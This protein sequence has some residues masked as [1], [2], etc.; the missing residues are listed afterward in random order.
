MTKRLNVWMNGELVGAW[1][2]SSSGRAS[3][4]Y[5]SGWIHSG[6]GRPLSLSIPF[7]AGNAVQ[8]GPVVEDYFENLLPDSKAIRDRMR[9]RFHIRSSSTIDLLAAIG[10]DCVGAAQLLP[11][12]VTPENWRTV[13]AVRLNEA[14][15]AN[16]LRAVPSISGLQ[17]ED[18]FR[19]SIAGAQEKTA[20]LRYAG[21]WHSPH[22]ATPT[23]HILKLP[24]GLVGGMRFNLSESVE[25]EW[26]CAKFLS[27]LGLRVAATEMATFEDQKVLVVERFDRRWIGVDTADVNKARFKPGSGTWIARLPQEDFCQI[28]GVPPTQKYPADGGPDM[29]KCLSYLKNS[30]QAE[31]DQRHFCLSQLAFWL[32]AATDGHAKN[33]SISLLAGGRYRLTPLYDVLSAWPVI[34]HGANR[35]PIQKAKLAMGVP[36]KTTHYR[37]QDI[38]ARHWYS[39]AVTCLGHTVW[40]SMQ[41]LVERV[42]AALDEVEKSLPADFP[43]HVWTTIQKGV[44]DQVRIFRKE[45]P[46]VEDPRK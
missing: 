16:L 19:I 3:F 6:Y 5:D 33:F 41:D 1:W 34:G 37:L 25:N 43:E 2:Y 15:I 22:G 44:R 11:E 24:L 46:F 9:S 31:D 40:Q 27:A 36:G 39:L 18:D 8:A 21:Q 45:A 10:R 26:L 38:R 29:K 17:Q 32:L 30:E 28:A 12:N 35:L 42:P 7:T 13:D 23:T 4:Q 20:L 14:A